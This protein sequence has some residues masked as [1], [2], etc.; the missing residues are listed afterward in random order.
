MVILLFK[1]ILDLRSKSFFFM[2][3][4]SLW[5]K[6]YVNDVE[7]VIQNIFIKVEKVGIVENVFH[8]EERC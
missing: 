1:E 8:L 2:C 7:I 4:C 6:E 3:I 5:K